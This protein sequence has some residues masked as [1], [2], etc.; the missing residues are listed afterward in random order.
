[1][2]ALKIRKI[3]FKSVSKE[4]VSGKATIWIKEV[5]F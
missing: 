2:L 5:H 1:M 4:L 3:R